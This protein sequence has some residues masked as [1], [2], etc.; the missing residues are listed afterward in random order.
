[1]NKKNKILLTKIGFVIAFVILVILPYRL[2]YGVGIMFHEL[3][4]KSSCESYGLH[5]SYSPSLQ[6]FF[7]INLLSGPI[8]AT[9]LNDA[10]LQK[11]KNGN[12]TMKKD[13]L[14]AGINSDLKFA[15]FIAILN[16]AVIFAFGLICWCAY[17]TK[18]R[19]LYITAIILAYVAFVLGLVLFQLYS[20][21]WHNLNDIN[22]DMY[23]FIS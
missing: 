4:H 2:I 1:M 17:S 15:E 18:S 23:K 10:D 6:T 14:L 22:A 9:I 5:P 20:T 13:V 12:T 3:S 21:T 7:G 8:D 16:L 19:K 11:L